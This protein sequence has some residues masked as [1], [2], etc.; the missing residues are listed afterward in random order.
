M[1][2]WWVTFF[3]LGATV[4]GGFLGYKKGK[5]RYDS[6]NIEEAEKALA[7]FIRKEKASTKDREKE[8]REKQETTKGESKFA[9][10]LANQVGQSMLKKYDMSHI[11]HGSEIMDKLESHE[12][13]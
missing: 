2:P 10:Q 7:E 13:W 1:M 11:A 9:S 3:V 6:E 8:D 5:S 4:A 12:Y